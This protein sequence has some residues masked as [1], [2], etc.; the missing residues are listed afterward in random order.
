MVLKASCWLCIAE[1]VAF[2]KKKK[3]KGK[4]K[5]FP[6]EEILFPKFQKA[7]SF[8]APAYLKTWTMLAWSLGGEVDSLPNDRCDHY[9]YLYITC[10]QLGRVLS[11]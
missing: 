2:F 9:P 7:N 10:P 11:D 4:I 3:I 6:S 8:S 1:I 5:K